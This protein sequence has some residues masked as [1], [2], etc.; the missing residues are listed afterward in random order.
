M[1]WQSFWVTMSAAF[2]LSC[3]DSEQKA[4]SAN[5]GTSASAG[6]AGGGGAATGGAS[7]SGGGDEDPWSHCDL[8]PTQDCTPAEVC[9]AILPALEPC[10]S[11]GSLLDADGCPR[12]ECLSNSDCKEGERCLASPLVATGCIS[13]SLEWCTAAPDGSCSCTWTDDCGW[14]LTCVPEALAP[15]SDDCDVDAVGCPPESWEESLTYA[16]SGD[17]RWAP[18]IRT[19]VE[20]CLARVQ[21][22]RAVCAQE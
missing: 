1:H 22:A 3:N 19:S 16:V 6:A 17:S 5:G 7:G 20:D 14:Y 9:E 15:R 2:L 11:P 21:A 10:G 4:A 12:A 18:E 8:P 13:S